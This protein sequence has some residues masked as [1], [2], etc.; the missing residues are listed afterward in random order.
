MNS[1]HFHTYFCTTV[2]TVSHN[3]YF[4]A[5]HAVNISMNYSFLQC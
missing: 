1:L 5:V 2:I 3:Q 4:T